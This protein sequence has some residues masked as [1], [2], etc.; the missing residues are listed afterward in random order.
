MGRASIPCQFVGP[1]WLGSSARTLLKAKT[2]DG[3]PT[4]RMNVQAHS[5]LKSPLMS[6]TCPNCLCSLT[7]PTTPVSFKS[8]YFVCQLKNSCHFTLKAQIEF[9]EQ[10]EYATQVSQFCDTYLVTEMRSQR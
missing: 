5:S 2:G 9:I 3:A 10:A 7:I 6:E 1:L 8:S 4:G